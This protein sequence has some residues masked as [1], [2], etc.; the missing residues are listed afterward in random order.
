MKICPVC[1]ARSFDDAELCFGCLHP[2]G[3]QD[4]PGFQVQ[5]K[6]SSENLPSFFVHVWA[7]R[8]DDDAL[9]WHCRAEAEHCCAV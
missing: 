3:P 8:G 9:V 6:A 4:E 2:F 1:S 7:D 5:A